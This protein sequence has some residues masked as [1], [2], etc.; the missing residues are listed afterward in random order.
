M[1]PISLDSKP[2]HFQGQTSTGAGIL[3]N[4]LIFVTFAMESVGPDNQTVH[5]QGQTNPEVGIPPI[6]SIFVYYSPCIFW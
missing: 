3:P 6:L 1:K 4:L 2:T 5:F